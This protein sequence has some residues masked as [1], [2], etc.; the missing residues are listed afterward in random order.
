MSQGWTSAWTR[1][2]LR[3]SPETWGHITIYYIWEVKIYKQGQFQ[4]ILEG[5][6]RKYTKLNY[7]CF[8]LLPLSQ[9]SNS[10]G[11][12]CPN[13]WISLIHV[14]LTTS[15]KDLNTTQTH[16]LSKLPAAPRSCTSSS[17][18]TSLHI[19]EYIY[20]N[21]HSSAAVIQTNLTQTGHSNFFY[22]S[23]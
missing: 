5:Y 16:T 14:S 2:D 18:H 12:L 10:E 23:L 13:Y 1:R 17:T 6:V 20:I 3:G 9:F 22:A 21:L 15:D 11:V 7:K 8:S 19:F 4:I